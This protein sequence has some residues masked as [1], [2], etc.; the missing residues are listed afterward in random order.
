MKKKILVTLAVVACALLLVA[1]SIVGTLAYLTSQ[2][3]VTNTF[4]VGNVEI[5]LTET[6]VNTD[7]TA[8]NDP[9]TRAEA[10]NEY[11]LLPG[12]SYTKD[13]IVHLSAKS[14][15]AYLFVK[16]VNQLS[17]IE[18]ANSTIASQLAS[19]KWTT[20]IS[21][22]ETTEVVNGVTITT[23][24]SIYAYEA[25]VSNS[26]NDV[27]DY[28]VFSSVKIA[29]NVDNATLAVYEGKTVVVTAYAVQAAGFNSAAAAWTG[30]NFS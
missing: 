21:E 23:V 20:K 22:T 30:A 6:E 3:T 4:T 7:G 10:G 8:K 13:P 2:A 14:E 16:V 27:V 28:P 5:K 9:A 19:N 1:G 18:D 17:G 26:T 12:Q 29:N 24:T 25:K 15:E 11:H